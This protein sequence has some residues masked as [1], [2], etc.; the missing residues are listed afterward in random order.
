MK[1][2]LALSLALL[3]AYATAEEVKVT[4]GKG[5]VTRFSEFCHQISPDLVTKLLNLVT[6]VGKGVVKGIREEAEGEAGKF[7][8]AFKG[9]PYAQVQIWSH[10]H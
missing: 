3:A 2:F 10:I 1:G 8:Y 6:L 4:T 7:Y 9:I 5:R